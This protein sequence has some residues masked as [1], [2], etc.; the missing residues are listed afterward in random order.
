MNARTNATTGFP[1]NWWFS[2]TNLGRLYYT[3]SISTISG[4]HYH[5]MIDSFHMPWVLVVTIK[6]I[7]FDKAPS[8]TAL[9]SDPNRV[10]LITLTSYDI[11]SACLWPIVAGSMWV[12]RE[13]SP[14]QNRWHK[15]T[16]FC[17]YPARSTVYRFTDT[18][19]IRQKFISQ[20][21]LP[22]I[23]LSYQ[24]ISRLRNKSEWLTWL[25]DSTASS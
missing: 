20:L 14:V 11:Q 1:V 23:I 18:S 7:P 16:T 5:M 25:T 24:I 6:N 2:K 12:E 15:P 13:C 17:Y 21:R 3:V 9:G 22:T 4:L 19:D 8:L 10:S